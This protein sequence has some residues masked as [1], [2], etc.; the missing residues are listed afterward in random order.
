MVK[1]KVSQ[2]ERYFRAERCLQCLPFLIS[3]RGFLQVRDGASLFLC[4]GSVSLVVSTRIETD[5]QK[6]FLLDLVLPPSIFYD[7]I[8][9]MQSIRL[10]DARRNG[11]PRFDAEKSGEEGGE[12]YLRY[13]T[14]SYLY[15]H[16]GSK[17]SVDMN[18]RGYVL[19]WTVKRA[20]AEMLG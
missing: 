6:L 14:G 1:F 18:D 2:Q 3:P 9:A 12:N 17:I 20:K 10:Q 7:G 5:A 11:H 15:Y 13:T 16:V 8:D 4:F 19:S